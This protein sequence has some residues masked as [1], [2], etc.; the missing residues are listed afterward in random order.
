[1]EITNMKIRFKFNNTQMKIG[2]DGKL[3]NRE[4]KYNTEEPAFCEIDLD[5]LNLL[6]SFFPPEMN[7]FKNINKGRKKFPDF[8]NQVYEDGAGIPRLLPAN[9]HDVYNYIARYGAANFQIQTIMKLDGRLDTEKLIKAVRLS[10]DAE[11]VFG[12]RFIE[13][14]PPYWKRMDDLDNIKFCSFEETD[15]P[16]E[17]VQRFLDSTYSMDTDPMVKLHLISSGSSDTL[18][19]KVNHTCCDGTGT[20]EYLHLLSDI[21]SNIDQ[22]NGVFE[23]TPSKRSRNDQD[24]LFSTLGIKDPESAWSTK[25]EIPKML[26]TFP[27]E[28]G[29]PN[30][31]RTAIC[32]FPNGFIDVMSTYGKAKGASIND[33]LLTALYRTMFGISEPPCDTPMHISMTV[34]LRRY[35]PNQKTDAIRNFSGGIDSCIPRIENEP[36]EGTLSRIA[37]MMSEIK[38][39]RPGLQSAVGL[40]RVEKGNFFETMSY[41]RKAGKSL[42]YTDE[43]APVL[44]NLSYIDKAFIKFGKN[45]VTDT[46]IVPPALSAPGVLLCASTYNG[47]ISIAV[48][49]YESQVSRENIEGFLDLIKKEIM[50]GCTL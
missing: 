24:R 36:F 10:I 45:V 9:G 39:G 28:Q 43:F 12:C 3:H 4:N 32:R 31:A 16:D 17:A 33:I 22:E 23:P 11:P 35:L 20:K 18:C 6:Y 7:I 38:N 46:Y 5:L 1:M 44:S 47:I 13:N 37:S 42:T 19:L 2:F 40:E 34:D 30:I 21:Y 50:E 29:Q 15:N 27:W 49:Y 14:D 25:G 8:E 41:Y 26:W 48:S